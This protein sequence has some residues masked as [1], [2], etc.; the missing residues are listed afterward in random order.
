MH[1]IGATEEITV[2]EYEAD[3]QEE[4]QEVQQQEA[5]GEGEPDSEQLPECPDHQPSTFVKGKPRSILSLL[6]FQ[7]INL[8][9]FML[10]H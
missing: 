6:C 1:A 8:S 3:P 4:H 9:P 5:Q 2:L 10:M 7:T